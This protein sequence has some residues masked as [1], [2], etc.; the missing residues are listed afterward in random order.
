MGLEHL[1]EPV[2]QDLELAGP[3]EGRVRLDVDLAQHVVKDEVL[4]LLLVADM[5]VERAGDDPEAGGQAAHGE[6]L[7]AILGDD[8]EGLG[9]HPLSRELMAPV[10]VVDGCVEP[11]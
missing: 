8:R 1:A 11:Q 7:D 9:D 5:M 10:L 2:G 3:A 4:E 6:G